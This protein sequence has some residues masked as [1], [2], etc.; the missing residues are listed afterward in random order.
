MRVGVFRGVHRVEL[1]ELPDPVA[2]PG[3]V[4]IDVKACGICGSDLHTYLEGALVQP[5]Q[6]LGHEFSGEVI[7]VGTGV[8]G[9]APG[10]RVTAMPLQPCGECRRCREG[11]RHL[12][13]LAH[14]RGLGFG[15][16]GGFAD[17]LRIPNAVL[18]VNVHLLPD[19]LDFD[20]GALVEPLGV[21]VHAVH[22]SEAR[23]GDAALVYGLGTIGLHVAQ[24]LLAHGVDTVL[25]ADLS[26]LRR[27]LATKLGIVAI[28][29]NDVD[30]GVASALGER[31]L[32]LVFECT[33][34]PALIQR[35]LELVRPRGKVVV[36]ALYDK[37][38]TIDP[39]ML[40]HKEATITSSVMITPEDFREAIELLRS[41]AAASGELVTHRRALADLP[42]AFALQCDKD[43]TV[44]VMVT[45]S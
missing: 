43:T 45:P 42:A 34:V 5:G 11:N 44:K 3:D 8:E 24:T 30:A 19:E 7:D 32:D 1:E 40:V 23:A 39:M 17:R 25:G 20:A 41:G 14:Q 6:V 26:P 28:D 22:R 4:V 13:E 37:L 16:P 15:L 21:A 9:I 38:A 10:D 33:G 2:G 29:G 36:V 35:S 31:E 18:G 12:C 27:D